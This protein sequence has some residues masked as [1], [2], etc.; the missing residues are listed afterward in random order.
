MSGN[1]GHVYFGGGR[2]PFLITY[3]GDAV[4]KHFNVRWL[5]PCACVFINYALLKLEVAFLGL[6]RKSQ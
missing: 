1:S 2:R 3:R 5:F 6:A 4:T